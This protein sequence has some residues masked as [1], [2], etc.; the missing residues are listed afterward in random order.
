MDHGQEYMSVA[1]ARRSSATGPSWS[2]TTAA[3]GAA[4]A[5]VA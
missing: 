4:N 3:S 5:P 1:D 2:W